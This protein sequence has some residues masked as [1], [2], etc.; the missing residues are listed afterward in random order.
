MIS[1]ITNTNFF[2]CKQLNGSKYSYEI[3][4]TELLHTVKAV[5]YQNRQI[6]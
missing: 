1:Y 3:P 6:S 5:T 4:I 2:I